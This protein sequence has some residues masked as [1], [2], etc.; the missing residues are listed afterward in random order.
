MTDWYMKQ[1]WKL[2]DNWFS[3]VT[4]LF[5]SVYLAGVAFCCCR[6]PGC[7]SRIALQ[8]EAAVHYTSASGL[9]RNPS[10]RGARVS[11]RSAFD[12]SPSW[13]AFFSGPRIYTKRELRAVRVG[14]LGGGPRLGVSRASLFFLQVGSCVLDKPGM[15]HRIIGPLLQLLGEWLH[16][17]R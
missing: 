16:G 3:K 7:I 1:C 17:S 4:Q 11:G 9:S 8:Q 5:G 14:S 15:I 12:Q 10:T 2:F 13:A 6:S